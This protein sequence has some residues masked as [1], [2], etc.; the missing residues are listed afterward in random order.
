MHILSVFNK[1][2]PHRILAWIL[3][4]KIPG[5]HSL[6]CSG[7]KIT[8]YS[9]FPTFSTASPW[10]LKEE[11]QDQYKTRIYSVFIKNCVFSDF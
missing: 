11:K 4:S 6:P 5:V 2:F 7:S 3:P 1:L 10:R 9:K 8:Q